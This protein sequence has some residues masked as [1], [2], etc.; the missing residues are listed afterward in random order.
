MDSV[1]SKELLECSV[2]GITANIYDGVLNEAVEF[3]H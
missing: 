2:A 3:P 1:L